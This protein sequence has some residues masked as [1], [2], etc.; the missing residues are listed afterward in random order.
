MTDKV[1][2]TIED[3]EEE[4]IEFFNEQFNEAV[5]K[6]DFS[7]FIPDDIIGARKLIW[8]YIKNK[9]DIEF[10]KKEYIPALKEKYIGPVEKTI[11]KLEEKQDALKGIVLDYMKNTDKKTLKYPD[12]ATISRLP[13]ENKIQYPEN[14][15]ELAEKMFEEGKTDF[16]RNKPTFDKKKI[17][18]YYKENKEVPIDELIEV[19]SG[20]NIRITP[21]K[22]N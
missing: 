21:K 1:N 3:M 12:L 15:K 5:E 16:L 8:A 7:S 10:Y 4:E 22:G 14:E 19:E 2:L 9:E 17:N 6:K 11:V 13:S 18:K 20:E